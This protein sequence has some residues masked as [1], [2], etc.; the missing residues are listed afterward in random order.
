MNYYYDLKVNFQENNYMFYEWSIND[1]IE[2][3]K[4]IPIFHVSEKV[5]KDFINNQILVDN[6]FLENIID[7]TNTKDKLLKYCALFA[8]KNGTIVLEFNDNGK[9]ILR[10]FLQIDDEYN[11][12][13]LIYTIPLLKIK[14]NLLEK[15]ELNKELRLEKEI[16][17]FIFL[18]I[19]NLFKE[20]KYDKLTFLYNEWFNKNNN[21]LKAMYEEMKARLKEEITN[22]EIKIYDLI[23]LSYNNV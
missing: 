15:I 14:Y 13:E 21:D 3:I 22:Q 18:E 1:E 2:Y 5:L 19:E 8:S 23:K 16:K 17:H 9:S 7:K 10:S 11:V 6:S 20:S 12:L 4:R